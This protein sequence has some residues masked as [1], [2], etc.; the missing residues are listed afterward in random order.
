[1]NTGLGGRVADDTDGLSRAFAGTSICLGALSANRQATQVANAAIAFNALKALQVHTDLAAEIAFDD[2][3]AILNRVDDLGELLFAQIFRADGGIDVGL[4]QNVF[5]VAGAD[6]VN[7]TQR[8]VDAL[9]R[10]DFY[11]NDTCHIFVKTLKR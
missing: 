10:R 2:V 1:M 7:V 6:A 11:A 8:D 5:G 4:G 9:I 3:F